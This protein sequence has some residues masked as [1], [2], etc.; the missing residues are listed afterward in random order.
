MSRL[1][2]HDGSVDVT[3][4][5]D[6]EE[7]LLAQLE[8]LERRVDALR[9]FEDLR[10]RLAD[11]HALLQNCRQLT[12]SNEGAAAL[13]YVKC[14]PLIEE[15]EKAAGGRMSVMSM[16]HSQT[17]S[18]YRIQPMDLGKEIQLVPGKDV[19]LWATDARDFVSS[20]PNGKRTE[21]ERGA[22]DYYD[23]YKKKWWRVLCM[24]SG[25]E[26]KEKDNE[27]RELWNTQIQFFL[28][29]LGFIV[30]VGNTLR[31]PSMI[32]QHGGIFFVPYV[33]SL[34]VFGFPLVYMHLSIGQYSGLSAN[35]AFW[36]MMPISN[37]IGWALVLLA[38]PIIVSWSLYYLWYSLQGV[39]LDDGLPWS[40]CHK[41]W[42][43]HFQCCQLTPASLHTQNI[44]DCYSNPRSL[45][46]P[47]AFFHYQVLNRTFM[48][49]A[50]IGEIQGH[51]V[52]ALAVAWCLV[53][54][55]VFKGIGSIGWAVSLTATIP[56]FMLLMLF[57]RGSSL[58]G[59][60]TGMHYFF[61]PE[62]RKL[63]N[64]NI[65][66]SAAEQVFY[67]LGIDAGPLISM[68]SFSR[69]RNNIYRDAFLLVVINSFTSIL[70]ATVIF[71]FLGFLAT[72]QEKHLNETI[73]HDALYLAFTVYPGVTS[74][75]E[76]GWL[77]AA[78]FF[79]MITLSA[80]DAEFAWLEMIASS[81][82]NQ[83]GI[84]KKQLETR[85]L[86]GLCIA[87]F[88][89][90]LPLCA[91]GGIYIFHSIENLNANWNSFSLSLLTIFVVCYI[92]GAD[93]F[94]DDLKEMLRVEPPP[95]QWSAPGRSRWYIF[96]KRTKYFFGPTG[97][98]I[99]YSWCVF[100]PMILTALFV[101]SVANYERV[102]FK[103][104]ILPLS[105]ELIAW[106]AMIG[107]L[108][109]VPL[110]VGYTVYETLKRKKPLSSMF[111][112]K[113][114]RNKKAEPVEEHRPDMESEYFYIDPISRGASAKS[115]TAAPNDDP[116]HHITEEDPYSRATDRVREWAERTSRDE[117][118]P[119]EVH[120]LQTIPSIVAA[121]VRR[122]EEEDEEK[123]EEEQ[124]EGIGRR[125]GRMRD[126][127]FAEAAAAKPTRSR[128]SSS[129]TSNE[130]AEG[131]EDERGDRLEA[132]LSAGS[133]RRPTVK[134]APAAAT[135]GNEPLNLFGPP[136]V[137]SAESPFA[138]SLSRRINK[139]RA[140]RRSDQRKNRMFN[141]GFNLVV[142]DAAQ[143]SGSSA[144][145]T[146]SPSA[147]TAPDRPEVSRSGKQPLGAR[148]STASTLSVSPFDVRSVSPTPTDTPEPAQPPP[149]VRLKRPTPIRSI[150][151]ATSPTNEP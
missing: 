135:S 124:S 111:S 143:P 94:M 1:H 91:Q 75:M 100:S 51:M 25:N 126:L 12:R 40:H 130:Y 97:D 104:T 93:N 95:T 101:L 17:A 58:K 29:C 16:S 71:Q 54:F 99:K 103:N 134:R 32:Y 110:T 74:F 36:K 21:D 147:S 39:F 8:Q 121:D 107:P 89:C 150:P 79:G 62:F 52:V 102:K 88:V 19:H 82:M 105:Y 27:V 119:L 18:T 31:F 139:N 81:I 43:S 56:Y 144:D 122:E 138:Q 49:D 59:A 57:L 127:L 47:E 73:R 14:V 128:R 66:K 24:N 41:E 9:K 30:G 84:K 149:I 96:A 132:N 140:N 123:E 3:S 34:C 72:A 109:V 28:S 64:I 90:G 115:K 113:N 106:V 76:A 133:S 63:W 5:L 61:Y 98:Y 129:S 142:L 77:W 118:R 13:L 68:A 2:S 120:Q 92:Y 85:L 117:P 67:E 116:R 55:G 65:W 6:A 22:Y 7:T 46:A 10:D 87:F 131:D 35:G 23:F 69:Y 20:L 53:F 125:P 78:L 151:P 37:G 4:T 33:I 11:I 141:D 48:A 112:T 44:S 38:V 42:K 108:F 137:S 70:C 45:T 148:E 136:P 146:P 15:L 83:F 60:S 145:R 86:V 114:W 80:L 50:N 26:A